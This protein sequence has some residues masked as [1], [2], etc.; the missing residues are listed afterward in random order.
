MSME[1]YITAEQLEKQ[2]G[3]ASKTWANWRS[4]KKG[5]RFYK[6]GK[7]V[8]YKMADIDRF[9]AGG[10]VVTIDQPLEDSVE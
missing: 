1:K 5:P 6:V 7:N 10:L 8:V 2:T 3:V 9:I 4:Q